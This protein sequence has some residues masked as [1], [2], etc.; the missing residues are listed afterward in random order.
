MILTQCNLIVKENAYAIVVQ[1][2]AP[3]LSC[4]C[5]REEGDRV[6]GRKVVENDPEDA[7]GEKRTVK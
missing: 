1:N 2:T 7:E 6:R 3:D 5:V 4:V